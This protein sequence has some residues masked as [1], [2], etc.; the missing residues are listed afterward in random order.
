MNSI[1]RQRAISY[2]FARENIKRLIVIV[3]IEIA[4][5]LPSGLSA[6]V[7]NLRVPFGL[8]PL[9]S[10]V[11]QIFS[12][13]LPKVTT[14]LFIHREFCGRYQTFLRIQFANRI[15][16]MFDCSTEQRKILKIF[17]CDRINFHIDFSG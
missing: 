4:N 5:L 7:Q 6:F 8:I 14:S 15:L 11:K 16:S 13:L 1:F 3:N 9:Q 17:V 2:S 12:F 10:S